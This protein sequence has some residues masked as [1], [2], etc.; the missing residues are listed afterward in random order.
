MDGLGSV[1]VADVSVDLFLE[2]Q[3]HQGDL[4]RELR[5]LE[6]AER[7]DLAER[8]VSGR[9][10]KLISDILVTWDDVRSTTRRQALE[11]HERGEAKVDLVVPVR[12]GLA[13]ALRSWLELLAEADQFC[14]IGNELLT[15]SA[16][17]DVR[18]FR[19]WYAEAII[20]QL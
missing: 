20:S 1:T 19:R 10:S 8:G 13:D 4:V 16:R 11:A 5:L 6:M 18:E 9:L 2:S 17:P 3:G 12:P 15:V 14:D 7:F